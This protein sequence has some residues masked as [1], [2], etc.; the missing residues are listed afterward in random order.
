MKFGHEYQTALANEGFPPEW[1]ESAIEYKHLKKVIK[2][3]HR[4]LERL[5]LNGRMLENLRQFI[6]VDVDESTAAPEPETTTQKDSEIQSRDTALHAIP[7]H[8][9][10]QVRVLVDSDTGA[11]I[12]ATLSDETRAS[13]RKLVQHEILV[14]D[15]RKD[16]GAE[17]A[18]DNNGDS[19]TRRPL[20]WRNESVASDPGEVPRST[21][22][23]NVPLTSAQDFFDMLQP[24]LEELES[25]RDVET[26][27]LEEEILDLGSAV[28]CG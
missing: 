7:E 4:E 2:K 11:P 12:D 3:V 8:F 27:N 20:G 21:R 9:S 22:W 14:A 17:D 26:H 19:A 13:L 18:S 15:R 6:V 24:K 16:L 10:P 1:V 5:G 28:E 23:I 25:L